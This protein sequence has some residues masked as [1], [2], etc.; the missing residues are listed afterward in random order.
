LTKPGDN[1]ATIIVGDSEDSSESESTETDWR[2]VPV[3]TEFDSDEERE[4]FQKARHLVN[5]TREGL[6]AAIEICRPGN[7]LSDIGE[8]IQTVAELNHLQTVEKYRGHG[9]GTT[10]HCAPYV[11]VSFASTDFE[12]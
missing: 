2:G 5:T 3:K 7:C 11:K 10:F 6:Y 9:I 4:Y 1:C 12:S 8:A